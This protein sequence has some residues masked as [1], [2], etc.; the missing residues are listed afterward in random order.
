MSPS[1]MC[2]IHCPQPV[3]KWSLG[4]GISY[5]EKSKGR[6]FAL[7]RPAG[8]T[9]VNEPAVHV[10]VCVGEA[11]VLQGHKALMHGKIKCMCAATPGLS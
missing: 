4:E 10:F 5:D 8:G 9:S 7:F 6:G 11:E 1:T 3:D 2:E